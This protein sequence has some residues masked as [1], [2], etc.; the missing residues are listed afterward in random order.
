MVQFRKHHVSEAD[1]TF[2]LSCPWIQ[3]LAVR[4]INRDEEKDALEGI[5]ITRNEINLN[6]GAFKFE[7]R[8]VE[9][10]LS[11]KLHPQNLRCTGERQRKEVRN[12]FFKTCLYSTHINERVF[13]RGKLISSTMAQV[14]VRS[15]ISF[16]IDDCLQ[17]F[18]VVFHVH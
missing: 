1:S 18:V 16:K 6:R 15:N 5:P 10:W 17:C 13:W 2:S 14:K 9:A 11:S 7:W 3:T 12:E 8:S 4:K